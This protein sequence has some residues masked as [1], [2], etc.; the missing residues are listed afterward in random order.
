MSEKRQRRPATKRGPKP[1]NPK[2]STATLAPESTEGQ[3][4]VGAELERIFDAIFEYVSAR[5]EAK[6]RTLAARP[7]AQI[8]PFSKARH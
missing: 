3:S 5:D 1:S 6:A 7:K 2:A 8:I 4:V